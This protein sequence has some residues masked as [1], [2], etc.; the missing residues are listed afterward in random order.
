MHFKDS[1]HLKRHLFTH[2]IVDSDTPQVRNACALCG[3]SFPDAWHLRQHLKTHE[4]GDLPATMP[5]PIRRR[6]RR[7][8]RPPLHTTIGHISTMTPKDPLPT[9]NQDPGLPNP[10]DFFDKYE[11]TDHLRPEALEFYCGIC[12]E[13]VSKPRFASHSL[14]HMHDVFEVRRG[15]AELELESRENTDNG[16]ECEQCQDLARKIRAMVQVIDQAITPSDELTSL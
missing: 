11:R 5:M 2:G 15:K 14:L 1:W 9:W 8:G 7:R 16:G 12:G 4:G 3:A 10:E 6:G 13:G